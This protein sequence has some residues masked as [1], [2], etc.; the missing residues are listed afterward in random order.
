MNLSEAL[1]AGVIPNTANPIDI[2]L[3]AHSEHLEDFLQKQIPRHHQIMSNAH[4]VDEARNKFKVKCDFSEAELATMS[5][6]KIWPGTLEV[7]GPS[8]STESPQFDHVLNEAPSLSAMKSSLGILNS[9]RRKK[10]HRPVNDSTITHCYNCNSAF[11]MIHRKHH[12][13]ACGRIFCY[14]CSQWSERIPQDLISYNDTKHWIIPGQASRVCQ[15]CRDI[16]D[17]FRRIEHLVKYFEIVAFPFDL[18]VRASTLCKDWREAMRI[19]LSN[20]RDIQYSLPSTPLTDRDRRALKSN[21]SYFQG[22]NKWLLQAL[23]MGLQRGLPLGAIGVQSRLPSGELSTITEGTGYV[24]EEISTGR[25][26]R[27]T[28]MMCDRNCCEELTA[29]DAIIIVNTPL[30]NVDVKLMALRILDTTTFPPD[31]ALFLP[32]ED[33]SVQDFILRRPDLFFD[34]FWLSRIDHG[35]STDIFKNKLMLANHDQAH[36]V[37]ESIQLI[38]MLESYD[39]LYTLAQKLQSLKVPFMGPFGMIEKFD[40]DITMKP[41]ATRPIIMRYYEK[42]VKRAFLYKQEDV[43]KDAH[44]VALIRLM[45]HLCGDIFASCRD[46]AF[47]P[48]SSGAIDIVGPRRD[49][50][51]WF[52]RDSP[53]HSNS[54]KHP[55]SLP[56]IFQSSP[57]SIPGMPT[58]PPPS[59]ISSFPNDSPTSMMRDTTYTRSPLDF[60]SQSPG[61]R[62]LDSFPNPEGMPSE[63]DMRFLAIYRVMPISTNAGFIEIV[64]NAH[65]L[66]DVL[67]RGTISNHLYKSNVNKTVR[68]VSSNYSASLAFWTVVTYLLGVGDRHLENIMI[69][70]DGVLFHI[71][72]GFVFGA[73]STASFVRLDKNLIEGLGGNDMYEA[74]KARCC[75]IYCCLRR[76]VNFICACLLRLA[77]IR[78]PIKGY[79]FTPEFIERFVTDRFLLG[80]TEEEAKEAFSN[81]IDSSRETFVRR[82]SDIVHSTMSTLKIHWWS[83]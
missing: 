4:T 48:V 83:Q 22:H 39:N 41:S 61:E 29:F 16:I 58:P 45:Y 2:I 52:T 27:C 32:M 80:Q 56:N 77:T 18:C 35:L 38:A 75:E 5:D 13:R 28:E 43:R 6:L 70:D 12:C 79:D 63:T 57:R 65:T 55:V 60:L 78:P 10:I 1:K 30:Y 9:L 36:S 24:G 69:R 21:M 59:P 20:V 68:E 40:S 25:I 19:Y 74:F 26:K 71:D 49:S 14:N 72:Y 17:N 53:I 23:K 62:F 50:G 81:I 7:T 11:G 64:P 51:S 34:F 46:A 8:D 54:F 73:D 31:I 37:Q 47:L 3:T 44:V 82:V 66:S 67:A 42:G 33:S 76:H 15:S